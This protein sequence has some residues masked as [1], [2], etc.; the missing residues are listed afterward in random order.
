M[1]INAHY[2]RSIE[3]FLK[4]C[5]HPEQQ[6]FFKREN[7]VITEVEMVGKWDI[8]TKLKLSLDGYKGL[9]IDNVVSTVSELCRDIL[10]RDSLDYKTVLNKFKE[11][12]FSRR[13]TVLLEHCPYLSNSKY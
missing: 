11:R 1:K 7:G 2:G 8:L 10:K 12:Y 4:N 13:P 9:N 6:L 3:T 5:A